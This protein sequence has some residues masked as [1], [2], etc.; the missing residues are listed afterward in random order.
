MTQMQEQASDRDAAATPSRGPGVAVAVAV[1]VIA[2]LLGGVLVAA[3]RG[4]TTTVAPVG[5]RA[6]GFAG[7]EL[8]GGTISIDEPVEGPVVLA[9][10]A[11]WCTT[12]KGDVEVLQRVTTD[13]ADAGVRVVGVVIDDTLDD[14]RAS[15]REQQLDYP[16]VLDERSEI[17]RAY[18][19][20][21]TP[22]TVLIDTNGTVAARW[23]G[24]LPTHELDLRLAAVTSGP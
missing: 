22:E 1:L 11:S 23:V 19:V 12:C 13:W 7:T 15:A 14:A 21:G 8:E 18:G 16:S 3:Q 10:W 17:R 9:F 2:A 5:S 20:R 24:P 6:P 4:E